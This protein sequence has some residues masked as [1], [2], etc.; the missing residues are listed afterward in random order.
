VSVRLSLYGTEGS[1]EQQTDSRVW[2]NRQGETED[3]HELLTCTRVPVSADEGAAVPAALHG[4]FFTG[5]SP[6]HPVARLP[7]EFIG[8]HNGHEG[9][10]QFLV[11][12]FVTACTHGTLPP[13]HVWAAAC[14]CAPGIVAHESARR[15]GELL[16]VP[17]FGEPA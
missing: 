13:N 8:L 10:H 11:D 12:D 14:Y 9:S 4:D 3:V 7:K 1:F 16:K 5:V 15:A 6:V 2:T 17:D